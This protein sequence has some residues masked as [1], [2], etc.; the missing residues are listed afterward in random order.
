MLDLMA[1]RYGVR[2]SELLMNSSL[3]ALSID[4]GCCQQAVEYET[5]LVEKKAAVL[6]VVV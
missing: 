5:M 1:K 4:W 3:E 2:P 6:A